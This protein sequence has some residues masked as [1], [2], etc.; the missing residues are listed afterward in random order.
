MKKNAYLI[1]ALTLGLA[2]CD[3]E[4]KFLVE[5]E[6]SGAESQTLYFEESSLEGIVTL[7]KI[8]GQWYIP[9]HTKEPGRSGVLPHSSEQ[10]CHQ[11]CSGLNRDGKNSGKC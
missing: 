11:L 8:E 6:V 2:A 9:V 4:P 3:S 5:G 7:D 1:M 10:Q